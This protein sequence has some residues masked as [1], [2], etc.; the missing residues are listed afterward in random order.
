MTV[1]LPQI[2]STILI[3]LGAN[4]PSHAGSPAVTINAAL[5]VLV[6]AG[7]VIRQISQHYST[8]AFPAGGGPDYINAAVAAECDW[9]PRQTLTQLHRI[10]SEFGRARDRRWGQRTLDLDLIAHDDL[11]LP[12]AETHKMWREMPLE[13][14]MTTSPDSLI[15]PHPRMQDR[16][17]V[18]VPLCDVAPDWRHP[19][20]G[21]SVRQMRDALPKAVLE[22]VRAVG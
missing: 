15:L 1:V 11:V 21:L 22:Q 6:T 19:V 4:M 7:A 18:L 3:A 10:E 9:T 2:R 5:K 8:P 17:F 13:T 16:A 20:L 14:Q 12:D